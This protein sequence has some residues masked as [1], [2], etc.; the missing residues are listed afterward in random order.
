MAVADRRASRCCAVLAGLLVVLGP[1]RD[2][3]SLGGRLRG[4]A[5]LAAAGRAG[6]VRRARAAGRSALVR[7]LSFGMS[8]GVHPV[9]SG[10]G[11]L[12]LGHVP[13]AR[14]RPHLA[15]PAL[16]QRPDADLAAPARRP[17]RRGRRGLHGAA[18][19]EVRQRQRPRL[20][21]RR[22][23]DRLLRA[24]RRLDPGRATSRSASAPSSA[25]RA[26]RPPAARCPRRRWSPCC[27]P[28]R[29]G[30]SAKAGL[31]LAGQPADQAPPGRRAARTT[32]APTTRPRRLRTY[33]GLVEAARVVPMVLARAARRHR[34][35]RAARPARRRAAGWPSSSADRCCS[36]AAS[37]PPW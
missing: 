20:P 30:P 21:R 23:P 8:A 2:A 33:R 27:P 34:R 12:H 31:V 4:R 29:D 26:W 25:T 5:A 24:R 13:G 16:L 14:R 15:L 19:A 36:P 32:A 6:R 22:H 9:R 1:V 17:D 11:R 37:P 18:A 7:A 35:R 3:D 28:R 10:A